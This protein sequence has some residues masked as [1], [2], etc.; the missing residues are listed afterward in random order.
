MTAK[1]TTRKTRELRDTNEP[2]S[3]VSFSVLPEEY[4]NFDDNTIL[5]LRKTFNVNIV[6][7]GDKFLVSSNSSNLRNCRK[8]VVVL[9]K[10]F[11]I[12]SKGYEYTE[13]DVDEFIGDLLPKQ[14]QDTNYKA[15]YTTFEGYEVTPRTKNQETLVQAITRNTIT[16]VAGHAGTGKTKLSCALAL[17]YLAENR[18]DKILVFRPL[19]NVGKDLGTLPGN[20]EEKYGAFCSNMIETFL[21]LLGEKVYDYMIKSKK[22]QYIPISFL[23]G[24]NLNSA[25]C[26]AEECQNLSTHEMTTLLSRFNWDTKFVINGDVSQIDR[27]AKDKSGLEMCLERLVGI[28]DIA[29]VKFNK[30]DCQRHKLVTEIIDAFEE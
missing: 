28:E 16:I 11:N 14:Y 15:I 29:I 3:F 22:I 9:E 27:R 8:A 12:I 20:I 19:T 17:K 18:Y 30:S 21:E 2:E 25:F 1:K 7:D 5:K 26:I 24:A 4:R 23:R 6:F 13:E 10:L